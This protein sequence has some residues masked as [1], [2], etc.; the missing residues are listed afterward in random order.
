M[1]L[2][3]SWR[4]II[5]II[6]TIIGHCLSLSLSVALIFGLYRPSSG[7]IALRNVL[8]CSTLHTFFSI[9]FWNFSS[10]A[11]IETNAERVPM[12]SIYNVYPFYKENWTNTIFITVILYYGILWAYITGLMLPFCILVFGRMQ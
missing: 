3:W 7:P 8:N 12:A 4:V 11:F 10:A 2:I 9:R 5:I 6:Y 1:R